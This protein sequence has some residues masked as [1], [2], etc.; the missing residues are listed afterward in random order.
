MAGFLYFV[1]GKD[2]NIR[3]K[4]LRETGLGYAFEKDD[5]TA[6]AVTGGPG[7][8][9][10]VI[11]A[12]QGFDDDNKVGYYKDDQTWCKVPGS[13]AWAGFI[14]DKPPTPGDLQRPKQIQGHLV[15][16]QDGNLWLCP[17]ARALDSDSRQG[18]IALPQ[19]VTA[20]DAGNW[21][22]GDVIEAYAPLWKIAERW[23]DTAVMAAKEAQDE[24]AFKFNFENANDSAL[25]ALST[26]YRVG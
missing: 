6:A 2:R 4:D 15:E 14:T 17:I 20:D 10:G 3:L 7:G 1:P 22:Q 23:W 13:D 12:H 11:V 19:S 24:N 8:K 5:H 18:Y 26:N 21:I 9:N 16:L 25:L